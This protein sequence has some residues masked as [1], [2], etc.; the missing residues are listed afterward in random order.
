[1]KKLL[2]TFIASSLLMLSTLSF[3]EDAPSSHE[4]FCSVAAFT[5]MKTAELKSDGLDQD[6]ALTRMIKYSKILSVD[7]VTAI[8]TS[9]YTDDDVKHTLE[10]VSGSEVFFKV[11]NLC[12]KPN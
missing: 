12:I 3:A 10:G 6:E 9:V 4:V 5:I 8:V 7:F 11:F 1:M 2:V